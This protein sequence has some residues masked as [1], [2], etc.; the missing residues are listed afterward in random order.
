MSI[1][2]PLLLSLSV[3]AAPSDTRVPSLAEQTR[4]TSQR[5]AAVV[6]ELEAADTAHLSDVQRAARRQLL[7]A[8]RAY[9]ERAD[10]GRNDEL[11]GARLPVFV[12]SQGRR[13]AMAELLHVSGELALV[14]RVR[15][16]S[17][18]AW[19]LD[20]AGDAQ[21]EGWLDEHGL[22]F[23][24]AA[25]IQGPTIDPG[26]SGPS[27]VPGGM[28]GRRSG[29][30]SYGGPGDT[31]GGSTGPAGAGPATGA[32]GSSGP[33]GPRTGPVTGGGPSTGGGNGPSQGPRPT[34][35]NM[36]TTT[37]DGWWL[38]WEYA[39]LEFITPNR[40]SLANTPI[41]GS[42]AAGS[43]REAIERARQQLETEG[44]DELDRRLRA[45]LTELAPRGQFLDRILV[46]NPGR[47]SFVNTDEILWIGAEGNYVRLHLAK[48][49][50]LVR[51][52]IGA[53]EERLD[54]KKFL[55]IH[56]SAIVALDHVRELH[57]VP[58]GDYSV[59]LDN[60]ARLTM[61]RSYRERFEAAV[62]RGIET[63]D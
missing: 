47:I 29:G 40:L 34:T 38:W 56:R 43:L 12:D 24:E 18:H 60:G 48:E 4:L 15:S 49:R 41:T 6:D 25:R 58:G 37:D 54:P 59:L 32:P 52:K 50:P 7:D 2:L 51:Q 63:I 62:G 26:P 35:A 55:R 3:Q 21:F 36:A 42:D 57:R 45:L 22:G 19:I 17:N 11:H 1:L 27:D 33:G 31:A 13:C 46:R 10:F 28:E 30:G 9:R 8:L 61:S 5:Y 14:E 20:L 53:L 44:P 23:E 16:T 39:K